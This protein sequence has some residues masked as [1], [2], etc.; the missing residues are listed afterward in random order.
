MTECIAEPKAVGEN[1]YVFVCRDDR[2]KKIPAPAGFNPDHQLYKIRFAA[3]RKKVLLSYEPVHAFEYS[4]EPNTE[5]TRGFLV[6]TGKI[7]KTCKYCG[8]KETKPFKVTE[9]VDVV[10]IDGKPYFVP[11]RFCVTEPVPVDAVG[12]YRVEPEV[13]YITTKSGLYVPVF[14]GWEAI[15]Q[16]KELDEKY[17]E[18]DAEFKRRCGTKCRDWKVFEALKNEMDATVYKQ[19][20]ILMREITAKG[21]RLLS[22]RSPNR[23]D[24]YIVNIVT[25]DS[26]NGYYRSDHTAV[27]FFTYE[28]FRGKWGFL[29]TIAKEYFARR[30]ER[31]ANVGEPPVEP[32]ETCLNAELTEQG[33]FKC[34]GIKVFP[35]IRQTAADERSPTYIVN[36]V[37][38]DDGVGLALSVSH[39]H[40]GKKRRYSLEYLNQNTYIWLDVD[41]LRCKLCKKDLMWHLIMKHDIDPITINGKLAFIESS[42]TS[43]VSIINDERPTSDDGTIQVDRVTPLVN[44]VELSSGLYVP[45]EYVDAETLKILIDLELEKGKDAVKAQAELL[46]KE[47]ERRGFVFGIDDR[48]VSEVIGPD[49]KVGKAISKQYMQGKWGPI[50]YAHLVLRKT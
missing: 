10:S 30:G 2:R 28:C 31:I 13:E 19:A 24:G 5:Y 45:L 14:V 35:A 15:K 44:Y 9:P 18:L 26:E 12:N 36:Y 20:E 42:E 49:L 21:I 3:E 6:F 32:L 43:A 17:A 50:A 47:L 1:E 11:E 38:L 46:V 40:Y 34:S 22:F 33:Y 37:K 39:I 25:P 23:L 29:G 41:I 27:G 48:G 16:L 4:V 7:E 8:Y